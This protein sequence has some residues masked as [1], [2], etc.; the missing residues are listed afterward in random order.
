MMELG[1]YYQRLDPVTGLH[2]YLRVISAPFIPEGR[3]KTVW[4]C[5]DQQYGKCDVTEGTWFFKSL[6]PATGLHPSLSMTPPDVDRDHG[7]N[8]EERSS[9]PRQY[10]PSWGTLREL[11]WKL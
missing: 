1:N 2:F 8:G 3:I 11:G 6:T 4:T 9:T 10:S 5:H 7:P